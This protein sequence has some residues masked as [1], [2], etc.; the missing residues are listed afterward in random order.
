MFPQGRRES[1]CLS[2][3]GR[4]VRAAGPRRT[5]PTVRRR[6]GG[7]PELDSRFRG[8]E[9]MSASRHLAEKPLTDFTREPRAVL[10]R[11]EQTDHG[12][13]DRFRL[14]AQIMDF[15]TRQP[16]PPPA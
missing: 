7:D 10:M 3:C 14:L 16:P 5:I 1:H 8:N 13:I 4:S 11:L 6:G 2:R 12:F 9:Q 15:E